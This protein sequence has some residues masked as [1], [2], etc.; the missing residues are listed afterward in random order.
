MSHSM[1]SIGLSVYLILIFQSIIPLNVF[2]ILS[3]DLLHLNY[4][5]INHQFPTKVSV[6]L[7]ISRLLESIVIFIPHLN[8]NFYLKPVI[9]H[10]S[11]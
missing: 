9:Y 4:F 8:S 3:D 7:L 10:F 1:L 6:F 11:F 5:E 2:L